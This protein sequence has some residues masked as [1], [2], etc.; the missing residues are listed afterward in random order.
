MRVLVIP[1]DPTH[2]GYILQPLVERLLR[3]VGKVSA[4]VHVM[5]NPRLGG[6]S[7]VRLA[8]PQIYERYKHMDLALFLPDDDCQGRDTTLVSMEQDAE[9]AGMRLI[10][11]AAI[12]EVEAWLLAGHVSKL[13]DRWAVVRD[14]CELKERHFVPFLETYGRTEEPGRGRKRLMREALAAGFTGIL[15]R[16]PELR[17]LQDRLREL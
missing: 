8:L 6:I 12:P 15:N 1:E 14:D 4:H 9:A 7:T 2:N 13:Q 3:S 5:S 16:C 11:C 17:E 10:G